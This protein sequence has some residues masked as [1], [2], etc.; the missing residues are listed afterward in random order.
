MGRP[1]IKGIYILHITMGLALVSI[2]KAGFSNSLACPLLWIFSNFIMMDLPQIYN[3]SRKWLSF[4]DYM[5]T[6]MAQSQKQKGREP[7]F[8]G[9]NGCIG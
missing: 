9:L 7:G 8:W 1:M 4:Y 5:T 2:S 6:I 3:V